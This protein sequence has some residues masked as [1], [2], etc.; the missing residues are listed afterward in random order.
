M[1]FNITYAS[2]TDT[3]TRMVNEDSIGAALHGSAECFVLCDGLGGHGMGDVASALVVDR[4]KKMFEEARDPVAFLKNAYDSSEEKLLEEQKKRNVPKMMKT[5][6][7]TAVIDK[8]K[9]FIANIGDS[10]AYVFKKGEVSFRTLDHSIPQM[11]VVMGDIKESEIRHHPDRNILLRVMG[12]EWEKPMYEILKPVSLK[13]VDAILLCSDGFWEL[14]EEDDMCT[15]LKLAESPEQW[16][17]MMVAMVR[18]NGR[19]KEMDNNSAIAIWCKK[20]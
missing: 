15:F 17:N 9:L 1:D 14:I 12:N 10:R 3:G 13:N 5:T 6:A 4:F 16:L 2:Y 8:K 11:L 19:G 20:K 18:N 7:V